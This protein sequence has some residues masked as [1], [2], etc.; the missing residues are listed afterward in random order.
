M[1][2]GYSADEIS[3]LHLLDL[4]PEDEKKRMR[5]KINNVFTAGEDNVEARFLTKYKDE[6]FIIF[7]AWL[8]IMKGNA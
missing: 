3:N 6:I 1:V 8:S 4:F 5:E 7:P 2:S